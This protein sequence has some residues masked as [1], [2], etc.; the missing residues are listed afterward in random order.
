[1]SPRVRKENARFKAVIGYADLELDTSSGY[2]YVRVSAKGKGE[3]FKSTREKTVRKAQTVADDLIDAFRGRKAGL[4]SERIRVRELCELALKDLEEQTKTLDEDGHPLRRQSTFQG[5]DK[6]HLRGPFPKGTKLKKG[7]RKE[8]LIRTLFGD[9]FGDEIDEQFWKTWVKRKGKKL[10]RK[11]NDIAKYLS[12]V[13]SYAYDEKYIG[14]KPEIFNPDKHKKKAIT[15]SDEQVLLFYSKAEPTLQDLIVVGSE[16]PL[17]PHENA[18]VQW[19]MVR[20][21]K[22]KQGRQAVEYDLPE[23]FV[24]KN[25]RKVMLTPNAAAVILRRR[26][27]TMKLPP[28][29]RSPY[30]FPAP[31]NRSK[32]LSRKTVNRMWHRMRAAVGLAPSVKIHFHWFR[33]NVYRRLTKIHGVPLAS[34]SQVGGTST[35]TLQKHYDL[36][37]EQATLQVAASINLP[38][39]IQTEEE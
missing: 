10:G 29:E 11:L 28:K 39:G 15:L 3:L 17:R 7:M 6:T 38:F 4:R 22:D 27:E 33:H 8:G 20:V 18:E 35:R 26:A 16:N 5:N 12:L 30:V 19:S 14:R 36:E 34:V 13:L 9:F 2:Y 25:A 37:E 21:F 32:P 31:K 23:W 24:K 1:M